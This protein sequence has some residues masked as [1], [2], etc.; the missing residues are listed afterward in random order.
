MINNKEKFELVKEL[1][2][3]TSDSRQAL[4]FAKTIDIDWSD[5]QPYDSVFNVWDYIIIKLRA[6]S[7]NE[8]NR[9]LE[10]LDFFRKNVDGGNDII[11]HYYL[12]LDQ[13]LKDKINF[14]VKLLKIK[15]LNLCI[16]QNSLKFNEANNGLPLTINF[17]QSLVRELQSKQ[18][19]FD[20]GQSDN[21]FYIG[22][23]YLKIYGTSA[24]DLGLKFKLFLSANKTKIDVR[25]FEIISELPFKSI[26]NFNY[27][28]ILNE[29]KPEK[30]DRYV[31]PEFQNFKY[32]IDKSDKT[33]IFN[34]LGNTSLMPYS[35]QY[36]VMNEGELIELICNSLTTKNVIQ[37]EIERLFN[38]RS[39]C[40]F[41]GF[42]FSH[43]Y[44]KMLFNIIIKIK[45]GSTENFSFH[46]PNEKIEDHIID[47]M[48]DEY[49]IFFINKENQ[50]NFL[51]LLI[52]A[53]NSDNS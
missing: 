27:D 22:Q 10:F 3:I 5:A 49:K 7:N 34:F 46:H 23:K 25:N 4:T 53:Y 45:L 19:H 32:Q 11:N 52:D 37:D 42:D 16:G 20:L 8:N 26:I 1:C 48:E 33:K 51:E 38:S 44:I 24:S 31:L 18:I 21:I 17:S 15:Q 36:C 9:L 41:L 30:Y 40:L 50:A 2:K 29:L 13:G 6:Y 47:I 39:Y 43:W 35:E 28:D 12:E 14:L